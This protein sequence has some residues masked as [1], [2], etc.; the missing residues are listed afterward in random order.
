MLL[1][2]VNS[3]K[4]VPYPLWLLGLIVVA[5]IFCSS[6]LAQGAQTLEAS[7]AYSA[8][9]FAG[10]AIRDV[11]CDIMT[12]VGGK[13]G[14]M[15]LTAAGIVALTYAAFGDAKYASSLIVVGVGAFAISAMISVY[16]G[17]LGCPAGDGAAN[18]EITR[19]ERVTA[20][21]PAVAIF[22][23][24]DREAAP[25]PHGDDSSTDPFDF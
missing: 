2:A 14:G 21:S 6:A 9:E 3:L 18:R 7:E 10:G 8:G 5:F 25:L 22:G 19:T 1:R 11:A 17:D 12:L 15:L 16:F 13:F 20:E 23:L 4:A 24:G